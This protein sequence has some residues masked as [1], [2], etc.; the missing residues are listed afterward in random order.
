MRLITRFL[1]LLM[2]TQ[3]VFAETTIQDFFNRADRFFQQNVRNGM[4][5]YQ[6]LKS[7]PQLLNELTR[8][9]AEMDLSMVTNDTER[10]SFL[11]NSYNI[12]V[13]SKITKNYPINS[14]LDIKGFFKEKTEV[15]AGKTVSL[16]Q[17][18]KEILFKDHFDARLHFV[19][20]C[21]AA[22]CPRLIEE[23]YLPQ[24]LEQSL[25]LRTKNT[26]NDS[27]FVKTDHQKKKVSISQLFQ[28]Y[29]NDFLKE[30]ASLIE[31]INLFREQPIP[32]DYRI[33]FIPYDWQLNDN[34][35]KEMEDNRESSNL[36]LYIPSKLLST[37]QMELKIFNNLYTQTAGFDQNGEITDYGSRSTYF[38]GIMYF[39]YGFSSSL[40]IGIDLYFKSVRLDSKNSSP[41]SLF[42][43][44]GGPAN[45]T[46]LATIAPKIKFS[47]LPQLKN[48]SLQSLIVIPVA[49]DLH[50][51]NNNKPFLEYD[52]VQWWTQFFYD[53][54]LNSDL[55]IYL[56]SDFFLRFGQ[57]GS[58]FLTPFKL[59]V[60]YYPSA[61]WTVYFPLELSPTWEDGG[62]VA[63]Y[64]QA[65]IGAKFQLTNLI[66]LE[67]LMT[68]FFAGKNQG[69]GSTYNLGVR[70]IL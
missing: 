58:T 44:S 26:L 38:T 4:I 13:I 29:Q 67:S 51:K 18:E 49:S 25:T 47:P 30:S 59:I 61:K 10:K 12:L 50:G 39:L 62:W 52:D 48:L 22:G 16:D 65:G 33:D 27:F 56:E 55:L 28:W 40:N 36:K 32:V 43:F 70:I 7:N 54:Q 34:K 14:P 31:Y 37:G 17:I 46:T 2:L 5:N 53:Y 11:I 24:Q 9:I 57:A 23:A 8:I 3:V 42:Q 69:A 6:F 60:N 15:L 1:F 63:W 21:A 68:D 41:F 19:L 35:T 64:S 66:E 20:V 45:R